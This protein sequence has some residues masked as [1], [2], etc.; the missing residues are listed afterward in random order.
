[1]LKMAADENT[2][3][4]PIYDLWSGCH[5]VIQEV[6]DPIISV[7]VDVMQDF[8]HSFGAFHSLIFP[9]STSI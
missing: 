3:L 9:P 6:V 4:T 7:K 8:V 1:M 5:R 2:V